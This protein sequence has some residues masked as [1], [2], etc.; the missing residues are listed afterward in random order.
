[1]HAKGLKFCCYLDSAEDASLVARRLDSAGIDFIKFDGW[2]FQNC[3]H[4]YA[5]VRDAML[6]T[7]R[8]IVYSTN[9]CSDA[10]VC[11]MFRTGRDIDPNWTTV[12]ECF[13]AGAGYTQMAKPGFWPDPDILEV[14][15]STEDGKLTDTENQAHFSMW[16]IMG[17]PLLAGFDFSNTR[18]KL[19]AQAYARIIQIHGN[20]E[21]I[22]LNQDPLG[23]G[24][25]RLRGQGALEVWVK[26]LQDGT[27]GVALFNRTSAQASISI[28]AQDLGLSQTAQVYVRDLWA[29]KSENPFTGTFSINVPSHGAAVYRM[30]ATP[31]N[32][33]VE[34]LRK[35]ERNIAWLKAHGIDVFPTR[36]IPKILNKT[37]LSMKV[38]DLKGRGL[39]STTG[40]AASGML[41]VKPVE[42][43]GNALKVIWSGK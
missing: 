29:H 39:S 2:T 35:M 26:D 37:D 22:A 32:P 42:S 43:H 5:E 28:S 36:L 20:A 6:A 14:G 3:D 19:S 11:N 1:M 21:V 9:K 33:P 40:N 17:A 13:D 34:I 30:S 31:I 7:S 23:K 12:M 16:C 8:P 4:Q 38:F 24:G 10:T 27:K 15:V 18:L 41:I 25:K